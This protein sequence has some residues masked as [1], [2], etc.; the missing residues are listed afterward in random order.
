MYDLIIGSTIT[1][2]QTL[3]L[4]EIFLNYNYADD[5]KGLIDNYGI[6]S[7]GPC[8]FPTLSLVIE[9][10]LKV[11]NFTSTKYFTL[12]CLVNGLKFHYINQYKKK[13]T[14]KNKSKEDKEEES[15]EMSESESDF[16]QDIYN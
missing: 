13:K 2:L 5:G 9:Q 4:K 12:A 1:R 15:C 16:I 14:S 6:L 11:E 3:F 8:Q 10:F 7:Y